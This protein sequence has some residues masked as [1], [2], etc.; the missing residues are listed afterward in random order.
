MLDTFD[1]ITGW[2][3]GTDTAN[4][5]A[6]TSTVNQGTGSLEFDKTGSSGTTATIT[7]KLGVPWDLEGLRG[8]GRGIACD[9]NTSDFSDFAKVSVRLVFRF[10]SSGAPSIYDQWDLSSLTDA[11]W[12]TLSGTLASPDSSTGSPTSALRRLVCGY[13]IVATMNN[14]ANTFTDLFVDALRLTGK[15][16]GVLIFDGERLPVPIFDTFRTFREDKT[17][18]NEAQTAMETIPLMAKEGV[19]LGF[20]QVRHTNG[21]SVWTHTLE[22]ALRLFDQ[23]AAS[24]HGWG[25][26]LPANEL[27]DTT[28]ASAASAGDLSIS[29]S[30]ATDV[31]FLSDV[32]DLRLG[33]NDSRNVERVRVVSRSTTTLYLDR[34]LRYAHESGTAVRSMRYYP[35]LG[36]RGEANALRETGSAVAFDLKA[37]ET[38]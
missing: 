29:V 27:V 5:A 21:E 30:S 23:Y 4:I 19:E 31:A 20:K 34:P 38:A 13:Q 15:P 7:K 6:E 37:V 36:K 35:S 10:N 16:H 18:T 2:A 3:A 22:D 25:V 17:K 1:S 14:A 28:L 24:N 8:E 33:P 11:Q 26:A 12:N 9:F 32:C